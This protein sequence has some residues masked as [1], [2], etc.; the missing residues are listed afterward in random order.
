MIVMNDFKKEY[1]G[2]KMHIDAAIS[3]VLKS[4]W[5]ILGKKVEEFEKQFALYS[6]STYCIGVANG[7]EALQ[8]S[9]LALDVGKGD[10]VIT[11]SN[12]AVA[13]SLAISSVGATPVFIDIDEYYHL[14]SKHIENKITSRTKAIIPVHLFGQA[15][16]IK[17]IIDIAKMHNLHVIEDACQAHGATYANKK[18]GSYGVLGCFSFYP[19]KNL[20]AYG[21]GGAITTNSKELYDKCKMLRNYGQTDRYRHIVKGLNSR[22]DELQAAIL[23]E[24]LKKLDDANHRRAEIAQLYKKH[25]LDIPQII[26]PKVRTESKH[27]YH[28]FV[29]QADRRDE[30]MRFLKKNNIQSLVHYPIPIHKQE[31]YIEYN[32]QTLPRTEEMAKRILSLPIHPMLEDHEVITVC[33]AIKAFYEK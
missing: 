31:C 25:L 6:D 7:L 19:T 10:E 14:D 32:N 8:I 1:E 3:S 24:K 27:V 11:V 23:I 2:N 13:T 5:H 22:L 21:D 4:G 18:V 9:L 12:S 15:V 26:L 16:N 33:N 29:I 30:L 17:K 20:G 28:L